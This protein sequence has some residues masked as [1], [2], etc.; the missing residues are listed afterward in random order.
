[1]NA[2]SFRMSQTA[3]IEEINVNIEDKRPAKQYSLW[4]SFIV[5]CLI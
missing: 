2:T 5:V 1:M 4:K 3:L